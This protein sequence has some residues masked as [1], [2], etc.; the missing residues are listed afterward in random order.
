MNPIQL[1]QMLSST[2]NPDQMIMQVLQN[3]PQ[4]RQVYNIIQNKTPDE[5]KQ[6]AQNLCKT[7]N[8]DI[9]S[10]AKQFNIPLW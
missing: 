2:N 10:L 9:N 5:I 1:I 6:Y 4:F 7:Q 3:N 8:I